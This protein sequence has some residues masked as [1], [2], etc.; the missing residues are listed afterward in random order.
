MM[1]KNSCYTQANTFN[2]QGLGIQLAV[3]QGQFAVQ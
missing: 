3:F 1:V 2:E